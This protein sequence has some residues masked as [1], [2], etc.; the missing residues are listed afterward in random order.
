MEARRSVK[1][2]ALRRLVA[3]GRITRTG[4]GRRG[5]SYRYAISGTDVPGIDGVPDNQNPEQGV[6]ARRG[7][8]DA[9]T[10][11]LGRA[12]QSRVPETDP[13]LEL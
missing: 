5:D 9:R 4:S 13:M 6:N 11:S 12:P 8:D 7:G 2:K 10:G 1:Q 3:D